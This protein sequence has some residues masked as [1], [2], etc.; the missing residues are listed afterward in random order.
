MA[1]RNDHS[2]EEL[3]QMALA[4]AISIVETQGHDKLTARYLARQIGYTPGT[5]YNLFGSMD[6][7][8]M[9]INGLT[10]D[11]LHDILILESKSQTK[12]GIKKMAETYIDFA[13]KNTNL[14][15][16]LFNIPTTISPPEWYAEK[17]ERLFQ[18]L[19]TII[20]TIEP[21]SSE[22]EVK[23]SARTLWAGIHG[24]CTLEI[25]QKGPMRGKPQQSATHMSNFL[26][27]RYFQRTE[28]N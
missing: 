15:L 9:Q 26:I 14:W 4:A 1:R 20:Q 12:D 27:D 13:V 16:M 17:I 3:K 11:C 2:R 8:Y 25:T 21:T 22:P 18:P 7:L 28:K 24:I 19:E 23:Q 10:L 5:L 6:D